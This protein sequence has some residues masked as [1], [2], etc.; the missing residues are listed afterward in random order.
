M[1]PIRFKS[2]DSKQEAKSKNGGDAVNVVLYMDD[3]PNEGGDSNRP[4]GTQSGVPNPLK[5]EYPEENLLKN[6]G[7]DDNRKKKGLKEGCGF[8]SV[9]HKR[10]ID[11]ATKEQ[12]NCIG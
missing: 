4:Y 8:I 6:R 9:A 7:H 2:R 3:S 11:R 5:E 10:R 12:S 1:N